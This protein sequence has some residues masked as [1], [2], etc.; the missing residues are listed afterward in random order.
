[1]LLALDE[2]FQT[3]EKVVPDF[4]ARAWLGDGYAG[5]H[6]FKGRTTET[7]QLDVPM[8]SWP[9]TSAAAPARATWSCRRTARAA[10]TTGS[11]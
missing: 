9:R 4:V 11:A 10:C 3:Y 6:A 2:Y 7:Y 5:D 1:V 8:A